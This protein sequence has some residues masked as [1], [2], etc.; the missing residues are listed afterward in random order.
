MAERR[1][2]ELFHARLEG[3]HDTLRQALGLNNGMEQALSYDPG[4]RP[5]N[6]LPGVQYARELLGRVT[7]KGDPGNVGIRSADASG[8]GVNVPDEFLRYSRGL[9][10][11]YYATSPRRRAQIEVDLAQVTSDLREAVEAQAARIKRFETEGVQVPREFLEWWQRDLAERADAAFAEVIPEQPGDQGAFSSLVAN[12]NTGMPPDSPLA[13]TADALAELAER[14]RAPHDPEQLDPVD[15]PGLDRTERQPAEFDP[16]RE[17]RI[18]PGDLRALDPSPERGT[19]EAVLGGLERP[20]GSESTPAELAPN[21]VPRA[22]TATDKPADRGARDA[23][24]SEPP[25]PGAPSTDA[26]ADGV[27]PPVVGPAEAAARSIE[28]PLAPRLRRGPG[29]GP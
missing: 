7:K 13:R 8:Q 26:S 15:T 4:K 1:R 27:G 10:Q 9:E 5:S 25:T 23:A 22:A 14:S 2:S 17:I 29:S 19:L 20:A 6:A 12:Q 11:L 16:T 18:T 28:T 24:D 3:L 21:E